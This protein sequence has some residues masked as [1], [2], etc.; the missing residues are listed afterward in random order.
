MSLFDDGGFNNPQT[1]SYPQPGS[2]LF[3]APA[4]KKPRTGKGLAIAAILVSGISLVVSSVLFIT[5]VVFGSAIATKVDSVTVAQSGDAAKI[6]QYISEGGLFEQPQNLGEFIDAIRDST[7][8]IYCGN[9]S[10]SGWGVDLEDDPNSTEDD[11]YPYEIVTNYHVVEECIDSGEQISFTLLGDPDQYD[12]VVWNFDNSSYSSSDRLSQFGDLALLMT[13][14]KI[15]ALPV[16]DSAP[17]AGHWVM[18]VGSP[19]ADLTTAQTLDGN[20]TFGR[21]TKY[22]ARESLIVTDTAIN[23]GNSGGPLI[24]S[25]GQVIGTN[26]WTEL[27]DSSDNIAYAIGIP[28]LC[29]DIL[30]CDAGDAWLW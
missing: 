8:T 4:P 1:N 20:I 18:A 25:A 21:V 3:D 9:S 11:A 19:G 2:N 24:N 15:S 26:T 23:Y 28:V 29:Q 5:T 13:A 16:A 6:S 17:A 10:G 12:A 22:F 27:K 7:F 30:A 14:K